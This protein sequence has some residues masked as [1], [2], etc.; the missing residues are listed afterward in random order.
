MAKVLCKNKQCTQGNFGK[1]KRFEQIRGEQVC[2]VECSIAIINSKTYVRKYEKQIRIENAKNK[3]AILDSIKSHSK[4]L[5]DLQKVFNQYIRLRDVDELC[6]S[7]QKVT[8][9]GNED[10]GHFY[11]TTKSALRFN[12]DNVH[13]QCS[14]PC[15]KDKH[16]DIHEYRINLIKKIGEERVQWLDEHKNDPLN[17]SIPD[18]KEFIEY[19]KLKVKKLKS[20]YLE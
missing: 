16:G 4:W 11:P 18:I 1:R 13:K 9:K 12:E 17:L 19:Y 15:N 6:I 7:C 20:P 14:R 5:N 2:S 8:R 3:K 10:A